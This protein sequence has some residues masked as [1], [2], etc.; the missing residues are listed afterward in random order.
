VDSILNNVKKNLGLAADYTAFD[1]DILTFINSAFSIVNQL[2]VGSADGFYIQ[3]D[4]A[5]WDDIGLP[6]NQLNL[7]KTYLFLK[8]RVLFDPPATSFL[9]KAMEA[10]LEEYEW[11]LSTLREEAFRPPVV[12]EVI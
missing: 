8:V 2:G 10:Q 4:T 3:D 1:V 6:A 7:L 11:R 9:I 12:E 5:V